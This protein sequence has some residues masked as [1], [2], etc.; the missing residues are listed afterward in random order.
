[1]VTPKTLIVLGVN[2]D[3]ISYEVVRGGPIPITEFYLNATTTPLDMDERAVHIR[4]EALVGHYSAPYNYRARLA[5][6]RLEVQSIKN[7]LPDSLRDSL[8]KAL[9][10]VPTNLFAHLE[11]PALAATIRFSSIVLGDV[12]D[13]A[14]DSPDATYN[15]IYH[16]WSWL[17]Q[18]QI[19][20]GAAAPGAPAVLVSPF[21]SENV[22]MGIFDA[23]GVYFLNDLNDS[24]TFGSLADRN[25]N[26][27]ALDPAGNRG[28]FSPN[29][30]RFGIVRACNFSTFWAVAISTVP[31]DNHINITHFLIAN[32]RQSEDFLMNSVFDPTTNNLHDVRTKINAAIG[33]AAPLHP[34]LVNPAD[35]ANLKYWTDTVAH[36]LGIH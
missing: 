8:A 17:R 23:G 11:A 20:W 36:A 4:G 9:G 16:P 28:I 5:L 22:K 34:V 10:V 35:R 15:L 14:N 1:M 27:H 19:P 6:I 31:N 18:V 25:V 24:I 32:N 33:A 3:T 2:A 29:N 12:I 30:A 26:Y 13:S 7:V 21:F